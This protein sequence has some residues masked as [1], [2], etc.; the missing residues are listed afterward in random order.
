MK[1]IVTG[2]HGYIG[3][4]LVPILLIHGH[5]VKGID[6][7][8]YDQFESPI[9]YQI[10]E[11]RKDI[12]SVTPEDLAGFDI[13]IHLAALS[14]DPC[15]ELNPE[16]TKAINFTASVNLAKMAKEVGMTRYVFSSS[17][18]VYGRMEEGAE[19]TEE[20]P[21]SPQT[22]YAKSKINTEREVASLAG[23]D[24]SPVFMR[25]A[26]VY[27]WSPSMRFDLVVNNLTASAYYTNQIKI[28]GDGKP[29]RPLIQVRD[30]ARVFLDM[31]DAPKP[32]IHNQTFNVGFNTENYQVKGIAELIHT[33]YPQTE[34]TIGMKSDPDSRSY[35]VKFDKLDH[36]LRPWHDWNVKKGIDEI[37]TRLQ[38]IALTREQFNQKA[39]QRLTQL[40]AFPSFLL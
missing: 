35:H 9:N 33:L 6:L 19:I 30:L 22:E 29:W 5:Q 17:C 13:M 2:H 14:N 25:N 7:G 21:V 4:V 1:I 31:V 10:P 8:L 12:R 27:G 26:T 39:Y 34:I 32:L 40:K 24:F 16:L 28:T 3:R 36:I 20:S 11:L 18:S 37:Y 15:G 38:Y 23:P